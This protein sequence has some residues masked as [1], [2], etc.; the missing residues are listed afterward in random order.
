MPG[1]VPGIHAFDHQTN[2]AWM[3]GTS[4]AMTMSSNI[5]PAQRAVEIGVE[6]VH[7]LEADREAQQV[8]RAGRGRALDRG[9]MLDQALDATERRCALPQIHARSRSDRRLLAAFDA[10]RQHAAE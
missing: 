6:V 8:G 2:K 9:A 4:P 7:V 10:D 1:L 3:A 5:R